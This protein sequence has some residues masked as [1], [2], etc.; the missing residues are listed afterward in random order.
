[1]AVVNVPPG[2]SGFVF[3]PSSFK[4]ALPALAV[5]LSLACTAALAEGG[6]AAEI[7]FW[8]SVKDSTVAAELEAYL[9]Q[10]PEGVFAGLAKIRLGNL[11]DAET[12]E[13]SALDNPAITECDRL[14]SDRYNPDR[15]VEETRDIR[16]GFDLALE[17]CMREL[18]VDPDNPRIGQLIGNLF[19]HQQDHEEAMKWYEPAGEAGLRLAQYRMGSSLSSVVFGR[20]ARDEIRGWLQKS[21]ERGLP[22]AQISLGDHLIQYQQRDDQPL[23][24]VMDGLE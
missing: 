2:S 9:S 11:L 24:D 4:R 23:S 8:I 20:E 1:M 15:L 16:S 12:S 7:A 3:R 22:A 17:T 13:T 10:F 19:Y 14:A 6:D 21:A 18:D 5:T